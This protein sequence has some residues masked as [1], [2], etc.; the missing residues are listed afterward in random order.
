MEPFAEISPGARVYHFLR[1]LHRHDSRR[2][3]ALFHAAKLTTPQLAVLEFLAVPQTM[4]VVSGHLGLSKSATSQ[5]VDR[6]VRQGFLVRSE[7]A[8]DRRERYIGLSDAGRALTADI[9]A[10][11]VARFNAALSHLP[12]D[13]ATRLAAV[14]GEVNDALEAP[15]N[16][17]PEHHASLGDQGR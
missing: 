17:Q 4:S 13:L 10:A 2:T 6:L 7:N 5:L 9:T 8:F 14:L 12:P 1:A 3:L 11:R 15:A 16:A